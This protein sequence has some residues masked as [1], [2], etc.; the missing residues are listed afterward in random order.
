MTFRKIIQKIRNF[1]IADFQNKHNAEKRLK[2][3]SV[4]KKLQPIENWSPF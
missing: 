4:E 1:I 2:K 3:Y